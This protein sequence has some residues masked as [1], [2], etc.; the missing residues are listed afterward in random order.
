MSG[1][2]TITGPPA[3]VTVDAGGNNRVFQV[4]AN[5]TASISCLTITGGDLRGRILRREA[6]RN[7]G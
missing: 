1:T 2:E 4:D 6:G 7:A 3:G 5:A